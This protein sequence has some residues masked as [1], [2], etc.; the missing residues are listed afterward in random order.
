MIAGQPTPEARAMARPAAYLRKSKDSAT[1]AEHLDRLMSAVRSDG[2]NGDTVVYDDWA[3]SGDQRKLASRRAWREMCE[4]IERGEHDVVYMNDLDRGG[5]SLEE[6]LRFMRVAQEHNVR[7][8]AGGIDWSEPE[9]RMEFRLRAMMAEEELEAAKR[10][11][12][13]TIRMRRRRGD[14]MGQPPYGS[15]FA[16]DE[17][18]VVLVED[19]DRPLQPVL[20]A[21]REAGGH[22]GEAVRLLNE[23]AVPSRYGRA[24]SDAALRQVLRRHGAL[25]AA[26]RKLRSNG[27]G[28]LRAPSPLAKL[29]LCHCGQAMTPVDSRGELYCY[30][31]SRD[32]AARHGRIRTSQRHVYEFLKEELRLWR[33]DMSWASTDSAQVEQE[34]AALE[35]RR[36]RLGI[37]YADGAMDDD[38]YARRKAAIA[39]ALDALPEPDAW[40]PGPD[41]GRAKP[42]VDWDADVGD[43]LRRLVRE[44]RLGRDM[45]PESVE[46]RVAW[47]APKAN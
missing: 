42:L 12:A 30:V 36:R 26:T 44:V 4:A 35:E 45:R 6:W 7:V 17:G 21:V 43:Q 47:L 8:I 16:R 27:H 5:R 46:W 28:Q 39:K 40:R 2:H 11:A 3:R 29:V 19:P 23:R 22:T 24:W 15:R 9:R 25:P 14:A 20:D 34:R 1:K 32:G 10:R 38:E 13:E 31:G 18:R 41:Y 37:A 33:V